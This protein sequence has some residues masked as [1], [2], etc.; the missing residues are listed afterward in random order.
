MGHYPFLPHS[1]P[2]GDSLA[3]CLSDD[4]SKMG[5]LKLIGQLKK[6]NYKNVELLEADKVVLETEKPLPGD[7]DGEAFAVNATKF[8]FE[9]RKKMLKIL[10]P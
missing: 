5:K 9:I 7:S 6:R 1:D 2:F 8:V 4:L 10:V 3:L